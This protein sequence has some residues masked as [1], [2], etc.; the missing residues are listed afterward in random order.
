MSECLITGCD[1]QRSFTTDQTIDLPL[2]TKWKTR[3]QGFIGSPLITTD[4]I[5]FST[6]SRG[7]AKM[8]PGLC[9]LDRSKGKMLWELPL[10]RYNNMP[11]LK[12][13][14]GKSRCVQDFICY[15]NNRI[16]IYDGVDLHSVDAST[17]D[18]LWKIRHSEFGEQKGEILH[19]M[20]FHEGILYVNADC[21]ICAID[22]ING[23]LIET[24]DAVHPKGISFY[25][26][27]LYF[28]DLGWGGRTSYLYCLDIGSRQLIWKTE[29][30]K[31]GEYVT[32]DNQLRT[33]GAA[34]PFPVIS[35]GRIYMSLGS[36]LACFDIESGE[37]L[38]KTLEHFIRQ[39]VSDGQKLYG[40]DGHQL[41]CFDANSGELIYETEEVPFGS[42]TAQ[43]MPLLAGKTIFVGTG[44]YLY[45]FDTETGKRVWEFS[46]GKKSGGFV[47]QP[48]LLDG[49]LYA[50]DTLGHFYCFVPQK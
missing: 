12:R 43:G 21:L 39:P 2:K 19:G 35:Q 26:N 24:F 30:S 16:F 50:G 6:P 1:K 11:V 22:P 31:L 3:I 5:F 41:R 7:Q 49:C 17:G 38:W 33:G 37:C 34:S 47:S 23:A 46:T 4:K 9:A 48:V 27:R 20:L 13:P 42:Y 8:T 29:I 45:A 32:H 25:N 18:I 44:G 14:E 28:A 36:Y 15:G 10:D 40:F